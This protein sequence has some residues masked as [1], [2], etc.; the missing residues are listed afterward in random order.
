MAELKGFLN[1]GHE[2]WLLAHPKAQILP[3]ARDIGVNVLP[4]EFERLHLPV[5]AVRP[6]AAVAA[7]PSNTDRR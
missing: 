6:P 5:N 4:C 7:N 2:V 3:R 1:R